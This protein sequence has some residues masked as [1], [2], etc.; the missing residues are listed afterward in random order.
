[1]NYMRLRRVWLRILLA[2]LLTG[3]CLTAADLATLTILH[4]NDL[5]AQLTPMQNDAGG[6]ARLAGLIRRERA[7]C[8]D[9]LLIEAGDVV[10]GSPVSTIFKGLPV[11]EILNLLRFDVGTFGNH[12]FDYGWQQAKK[13]V[14]TG[15]QATVLANLVDAKGGSFL[16]LPYVVL[17]VNGLRVAVIGLITADMKD[18][19]TP[20]LMGP[21][22][23]TPVYQAAQ[24][25]ASE[26]RKKADVVVL[27]GHLNTIEEAAVLHNI[28]DIAIVVTGHAHNGM[29]APLSE[30]NRVL[31]RVKSNGQELGRLETVVDKETK[32]LAS[33]NWK[34]IPVDAK[35]PVA[36]D[37][38]VQVKRWESEVTSVVDQPIGR[39]MRE[40]PATE[41]RR[42]I[43]KA[44]REATGA[45]FAF[46]N[47]GG[48]RDKLPMGQLLARHVWNIMPFDNLVVTA[49]VK[50][51][52][53]PPVVTQ[54]A[55]TDPDKEYTLAVSDFTAANMS[56]P[57][58]LG[59][60]G[61][62][63]GKDGPLLRDVI[64]DWVRRQKVLE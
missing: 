59:V 23:V 39:A 20:A 27:L 49:R 32:S 60:S 48:V 53:L 26:A 52:A 10:Q 3:V 12:E 37:V 41:V 55:A 31:V 5:H 15:T 28:P 34:R 18:L 57:G 8:K 17:P 25:Y 35:A 6:M 9:C 4:I 7:G 62:E 38:A 13:F 33:W 64:I 43:E 54:G 19:S 51:S 21:W 40:I 56:A 14:D 29:Q 50:G 24:R 63:F 45:D 16:P 22:Q 46:M 44:M 47:P 42:L 36:E 30:G 1:M 61:L 58:Q 2:G 11:Y